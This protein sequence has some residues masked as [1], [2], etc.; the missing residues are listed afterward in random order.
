MEADPFSVYN[1]VMGLAA[2]L[3]L[4]YLLYLETDV[5]GYRRFVLVTASG[6]F[7]FAV[8]GPAFELWMPVYVHLVHGMAALLVV[9]GL[10]DPVRNDLRA[11]EWASL[12]FEEPSRMRRPADWMV[13]MDDR[14]LSLFRTADLVLS[15]AIV[16]YNLGHS[17]EEV[18]RRL[19]EMREY[20]LIERVDRGKYRMTSTGEA[21]LQGEVHVSPGEDPRPTTA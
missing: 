14:I 3:G 6:L 1:A 18:N 2:G 7:V 19:S 10:Y 15:P 5:V 16:A 8:V 20:G 9:L 12:L 11:G 21:Y 17:R 4:L 13:P